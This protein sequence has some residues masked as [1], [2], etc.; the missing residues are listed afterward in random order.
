MRTLL[1]IACLTA[2]VA[3]QQKAQ[4]MTPEQNKKMETL[5]AN[6]TPRCIGRHMIDLP[7]VFVLNSES[8]TEID[9]VTVTIKPMSKPNFEM[10]FDA[11]QKRLAGLFQ[12]GKDKNRP[13]LRR[14]IPLPAPSIGGVF[15]RA[16]SESNSDRSGRVLQ[17]VG[18]RDG[19]RINSLIKATDLTFPEDAD[20][21]IA[22]QLRTDVN[23]KLA[24]LLKVYERLR[25][26]GLNEIPTEPGLCIANGFVKGP[27]NPKE[28]TF[29]PFHLD[30]A[31]DV[32]FGFHSKTD[33]REKD[34]ILQR[35]ADIE[36][37]MKE[38]GASTVRKGKRPLNGVEA[39]E[40]LSRGPT[41]SHVQGTMFQLMAN[42]T[43]TDPAKPNIELGL[44]NGF[45]IPRPELPDEEMRRLG[46][47][48]E[49]KKASLTEAEA[50]AIWDKVTATLRPRPGAF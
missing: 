24:L 12:L 5:T 49:L 1:F 15:D 2:L 48:E 4:S 32:F 17:A 34:T 35:S 27:A 11:T 26:R 3:C 14:T 29:F 20:D 30:G 7:Q 40:W 39:E 36:K 25:G 47:Y 46:L 21:P 45:S 8:G 38:A 19:Y 16:E 42:E 44:F 13:H 18:W 10:L 37:L 23:E 43:S 50:V 22:K 6:M 33:V 28:Q 9:G 41:P 31:P